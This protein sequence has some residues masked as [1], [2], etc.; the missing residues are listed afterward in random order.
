MTF[1][2]NDTIFS[3]APAS[4]ANVGPCYDIMGY[5]LDYVGDF[6]EGKITSEKGKL[7]FKNVEGPNNY[8]LRNVQ[9]NEN[10]AYAVADSIW[11]KYWNSKDHPF[12][13][14]LTLHKYMPVSS[15]LGSSAASGVAA[16]KIVYEVLNI[17]TS[18]SDFTKISNQLMVAEEVTSGTK[19]PD[20]VVPSFFGGFWIMLHDYTEN[21]K[22]INNLY[23]VIIKPNIEISTEDARKEVRET[24]IKKYICGPDQE[25]AS[26]EILDLIQTQSGLA[27]KMASA[28]KD[29]DVLKIGKTLDKNEMLETA[30]SKLIPNFKLVKES[31]KKAG[32]IGC[33]IS[34]A[35]PS[36]VAITKSM[37]KAHDIKN[38]MIESFK[39]GGLIKECN[40][41]ISPI[42]NDGAKIVRSIEEEIHRGK[43][44]HNFY[45]GVNDN[46]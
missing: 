30:R 20:N 39:A 21:F 44:Y 26:V 6:V 34:G 46:E 42:N 41:L 4:V 33:S 29:N 25:V 23:S 15:G 3:F 35:G 43:R 19:H 5:C 40:W 32:A 37:E 36:L 18:N 22:N 17:N 10:A 28:V 1:N 13:L 7:R 11:N 31:A 8:A 27:L 38:A 9:N 16:G 12:G 45:N 2:I 14:E 24:I